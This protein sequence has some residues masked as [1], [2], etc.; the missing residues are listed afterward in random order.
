M[1][2]WDFEKGIEANPSAILYV[3]T[4]VESLDLT[5]YRNYRSCGM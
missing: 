4:N 5:G 2:K 1:Y 3:E